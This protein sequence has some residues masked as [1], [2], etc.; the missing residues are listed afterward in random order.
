MSD[1]KYKTSAYQRNASLQ[2]YNKIITA[3]D[4][5]MQPSNPEAIAPAN[6]D[7]IEAWWIYFYSQFSNPHELFS[8]ARQERWNRR[9]YV[10]FKRKF[11]FCPEVELC[12]TVWC[13]NAACGERMPK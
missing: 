8:L 2:H 5:C 3:I 7:D 10:R 11:K 12:Y 4:A 6:S 9:I 13:D 1:K